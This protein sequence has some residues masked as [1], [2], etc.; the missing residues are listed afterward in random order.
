MLVASNAAGT[1]HAREWCRVISESDDDRNVSLRVASARSRSLN[2]LLLFLLG[3][4]FLLL[5]LEQMLPVFVHRVVVHENGQLRCHL[6]RDRYWGFAIFSANVCFLAAA[7]VSLTHRK[8]GRFWPWFLLVVGL[9]QI[10]G[11]L[12]ELGWDG[13]SQIYPPPVFARPP[14]WWETWRA[15]RRLVLDP[16][17]LLRLGL[18]LPMVA[19]AL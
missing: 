12:P 7:W 16:L 6:E 9:I 8:G 10:L 17:I 4:V 11:A 3:L 14:Q 19:M 18:H 1:V 13:F 15:T 2:P 5:G